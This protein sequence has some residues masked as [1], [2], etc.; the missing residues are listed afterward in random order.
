MYLIMEQNFVLP[1]VWISYLGGE[2]SFVLRYNGKIFAVDPVETTPDLN[3]DVILISSNSSDKGFVKLLK[4]IKNKTIYAPRDLIEVIEKG[5]AIED[6]IDILRLDEIY[7]N[8]FETS[9]GKY[10]FL[11]LFPNGVSI[12][13]LNKDFDPRKL[14]FLKSEEINY[15]VVSSKVDMNKLKEII[16]LLKPE[17]VILVPRDKKVKEELKK[18]GVESNVLEIDEKVWFIL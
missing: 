5:K 14:S 12:L 13:F 17:F 8:A 11:F 4:N 6:K 9:R 18:E 3:I 15:L 1:G 2:S 16:K 10:S 7:V